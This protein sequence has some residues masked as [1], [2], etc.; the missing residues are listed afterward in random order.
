M[1]PDTN[2]TKVA[3]EPYRRGNIKP[4]DNRFG[5]PDI[6]D[7][8]RYIESLRN[9]IFGNLI[10]VDDNSELLLNPFS[11]ESGKLVY[12]SLPTTRCP[13]SMK[14]LPEDFY[15][16]MSGFTIKKLIDEGVVI[17][18]CGSEIPTN[19]SGEIMSD[20]E[21][22]KYSNDEYFNSYRLHT[23]SIEVVLLD[24]GE[25]K[26]KKSRFL[27]SQLKSLESETHPSIHELLKKNGLHYIGAAKKV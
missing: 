14:H 11:A 9:E 25:I 20:E 2:E 23:F 1:Q 21:A 5:D 22:E 16:D 19:A 18:Q 12:L 26:I 27:D 8:G 24:S 3:P 15:L 4:A 10:P 6:Y 17:A 7:N 13:G